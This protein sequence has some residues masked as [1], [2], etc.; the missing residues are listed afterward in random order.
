MDRQPCNAAGDVQGINGRKTHMNDTPNKLDAYCPAPTE[1]FGMLHD[2]VADTKLDSF[3]RTCLIAAA[4]VM[5]DHAS[6]QTFYY[7]VDALRT[8][9]PMY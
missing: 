7:L 6:A 9:R 4:Y 5:Y 2:I 1:A 3:Q 8:N